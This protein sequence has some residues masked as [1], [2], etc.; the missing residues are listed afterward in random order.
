M[1]IL[2]I[3]ADLAAAACSGAFVIMYARRAWWRSKTGRNLMFLSVAV[4]VAALLAAC[5]WLL[6]AVGHPAWFQY[7]APVAAGVW[8]IIAGGFI[9]RIGDLKRAERQAHEQN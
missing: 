8:I 6:V 2:T 3:I 5:S 4:C 9:A 7:L 1:I